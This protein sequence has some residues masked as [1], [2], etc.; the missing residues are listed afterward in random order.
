MTSKRQHANKTSKKTSQGKK[1][2]T[3]GSGRLGVKRV[4]QKKN[5]SARE[6][7]KKNLHNTSK[8]KIVGKKYSSHLN[9]KRTIDRTSTALLNTTKQV[10]KDKLLKQARS[11]LT[12]KLNAINTKRRQILRDEKE[13][14]Q[15]LA[16]LLARENTTIGDIHSSQQQ[17]PPTIN[18]FKDLDNSRQRSY[19][20]RQDGTLHLSDGDDDVFIANSSNDEA[21]SNAEK[22]QEDVTHS[23]PANN[24]P[25]TSEGFSTPLASNR[26]FSVMTNPHSTSKNVEEEDTFDS[27][28]ARNQLKLSL[29]SSGT[30]LKSYLSKIGQK[31]ERQYL[32]LSN[33]GLK[34]KNNAFYLGSLKVMFENDHIKVGETIYSV[35]PGLLELIFYKQPDRKTITSKDKTAYKQILIDTS[36]HK[37]FYSRHQ[38]IA[39]SRGVKYKSFIAPLFA[40]D[41]TVEEGESSA[42]VSG[43]GGTEFVHWW[44]DP[45]TL[46]DR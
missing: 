27:P 5:I 24:S 10:E 26:R 40:K 44:F 8:S 13:K 46:I 21:C 4:A 18:V 1:N 30:L 14:T 41:S 11:N 7:R 39:A 43:S 45:N 28:D 2:K 9:E 37:K 36:A 32:D 33:T 23:F 6:K 3:A 31:K 17:Q 19:D 29:A 35:T 22:G 20:Y 16:A 38:S 12:A 25:Q 42:E 34:V 15:L